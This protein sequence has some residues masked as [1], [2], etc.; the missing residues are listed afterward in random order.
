VDLRVSKK[1]LPALFALAQI[2]LAIPSH[3]QTLIESYTTQLSEQ[4]HFSSR[5]DRLQNAAAIIRQDRAN[6]HKFGLRDPG[7]QHDDFFAS[8]AN[9][10][11]LEEMINAG[12]SEPSAIRSI[13]NGTPAVRV[14]IF[15]SPQGRDFVNVEVADMGANETSTFAPARVV[16]APTG[17]ASSQPTEVPKGSKLRA[18]LF[19]LAR[20]AIENQAGQPV[21]FAG[22]LKQLK[23]WAFFAGKIVDAKGSTIEID[24]ISDTFAIWRQTNG[25]W[26]FLAGGAG[27]SDTGF[28]EEWINKGAPRGLLY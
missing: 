27:I 28:H 21:K 8:A 7:D 2:G 11:A 10:E 17:Q 12:T 23:D 13:V 20:P 6:F 16:S 14:S 9:R 18:T 25:Q 19:D 26:M 24:G 15:R 22:S 1:L 4:D 5:G 3:A